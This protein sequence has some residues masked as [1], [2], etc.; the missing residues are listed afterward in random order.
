MW[1]LK[2][3]LQHRDCIYT[4]KTKKFKIK[5]FMYP[6]GEYVEK[7]VHLFSAIHIL[8]GKE[9]NKKK[10]ISY[11]RN[12]KKVI[13]LEI[14]Q[15]VIFTLVKEEN[16]TSKYKQVYNSK[17]FFPSPMINSDDGFEYW[18]IASWDRTALANIIN[19]EKSK[20]FI[21]FE[22]IKFVEKKLDEVY[23]LQLLPRLSLKQ[24]ET[25][26][27]AVNKGYYK[28]PKKTNLNEIAKIMRVSK[29]AVH[30]FLSRAES[31]IIPF[32]NK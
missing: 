5:D 13:K 2:F 16:Y 29:S 17:L 3:K 23:L 25:F 21:H 10:Y 7:G 15:N 27:L 9:S 24:R 31:K 30:E 12:C 1:Y 32:L 14:S 28:F 19:L 18:E 22:I 6:L 11:L 20:I 26:E 8:E 4:Q